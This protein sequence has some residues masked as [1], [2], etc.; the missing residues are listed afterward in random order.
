[1]KNFSFLIFA[2]LISL[3]TSLSPEEEYNLCNVNIERGKVSRRFC[4]DQGRSF[5]EN[6][7]CMVTYTDTESQDYHV[8]YL[9]TAKKI[10][11]FEQF[12]EEIRN[13]IKYYYSEYAPVSTINYFECSSKYLKLTFL[14]IL[15]LLF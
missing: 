2:S 13:E 14:A 9:M 12:Y 5:K 3:F 10:I 7:C 4:A 1:M 11:Y 15:S 6:I 8:C